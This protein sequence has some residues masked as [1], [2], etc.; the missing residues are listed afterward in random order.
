MNIS[1]LSSLIRPGRT[2]ILPIPAPEPPDSAKAARVAES[3]LHGVIK[4][5][6][7]MRVLRDGR[8]RLLDR[9]PA[10]HSEVDVETLFRIER[11]DNPLGASVDAGALLVV[12]E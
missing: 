8:I 2:G 12:I 4:V 9:E 11:D 5:D 1:S 10:A 6:N 7:E 3:Q